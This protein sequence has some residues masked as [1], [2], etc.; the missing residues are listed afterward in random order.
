MSVLCDYAKYQEMHF[1]MPSYVCV[2]HLE[3]GNNLLF[4]DSIKVSTRHVV[5]Y[6][7]MFTNSEDTYNLME[8]L[9]NLAMRQYV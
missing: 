9:A 5:Y 3:R 4:P 7:S 8:Q 1:P 2:Q 6:F